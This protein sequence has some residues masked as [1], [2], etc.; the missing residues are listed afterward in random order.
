MLSN[1]AEKTC[2]LAGTEVVKATLQSPVGACELHTSLMS[3]VFLVAKVKLPLYGG[4]A[5][6]R[7]ADLEMM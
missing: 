1:T 3:A 7:T 6:V 2:E 5:A 4:E